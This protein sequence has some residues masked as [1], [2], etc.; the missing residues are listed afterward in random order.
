MK[1]LQILLTIVLVAVG[2]QPIAI[3]RGGGGGGGHGGGGGFGGGHGGGF[4]GGGRSFGGG[5]GGHYASSGSHFGGSHVASGSSASHYAGT[6][7]GLANTHAAHGVGQRSR[8]TGTQRTTG[9]TGQRTT[10]KTG[11]TTGRGAMGKGQGKTGKT[12]QHRLS[13]ANTQKANHTKNIANKAKNNPKVNGAMKN[14]KNNKNWNKFHNNKFF[15]NFGFFNGFGW[16]GFGLFFDFFLFSPFLLFPYYWWNSFADF[17]P[18]LWPWYEPF[19]WDYDDYAVEVKT[20][21]LD[22]GD[23]TGAIE[24]IE[25]RLNRIEAEVQALGSTDDYKDEVNKLAWMLLDIKH[26]VGL[27]QTMSSEQKEDVNNRVDELISRV[28]QSGIVPKDEEAMQKAN[29]DL[30]QAL[31]GSDADTNEAEDYQA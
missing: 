7:H 30:R 14:A 31:V 25:E 4:S 23:Y 12:G 18:D 20:D 16:L 28:D 10:G 24:T 1:K 26:Q 11:R 6:T 13:H 9:R 29:E 2:I 5:G 27:L 15:N 21:Y 17:G 3:A 8:T 19:Y 22:D